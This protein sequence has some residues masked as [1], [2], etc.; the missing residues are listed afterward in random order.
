[1]APP[2]IGHSLNV[3]HRDRAST[4]HVATDAAGSAGRGPR[5]TGA[6]A[7]MRGDGFGVVGIDV[8][9]DDRREADFSAPGYLLR[10]PPP[11]KH[12]ENR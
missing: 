4:A 10:P 1:M 2:H 8:M 9:A 12:P 5:P 7:G 3:A 11:D 6:V